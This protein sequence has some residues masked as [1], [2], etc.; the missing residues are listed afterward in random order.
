MPEHSTF[1]AVLA[2]AKKGAALTAHAAGSCPPYLAAVMVLAYAVRLRGIEVNTLTDAHVLTESI[3]SNRRKG[4]RDNVTTWTD[5][6]RQAV[7]WLQNYRQERI[8]AHSRPILI[9]ADER[10][11]IVSESGT[12]L[13]TSA[14]AA[15]DSARHP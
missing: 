3:R 7:R 4:S 11:L 1:D 6:L 13:T 12:R 5:D 10:P 2:F 8:E 15:D 9:N 14:I